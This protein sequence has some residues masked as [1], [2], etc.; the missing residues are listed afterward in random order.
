EV[1]ARPGGEI[2]QRVLESDLTD[3]HFQSLLWKRDAAFMRKAALAVEPDC[4]KV[5][6][7]LDDAEVVR[8]FSD[9]GGHD[10]QSL[11]EAFLASRTSDR[12]T[13]IVAHTIKGHRLR[14]QAAT[15]NHSA[16]PD[17]DEV[18]ELL[19]AAGL[20]YDDPY[21]RFPADSPEGRWLAERGRYLRE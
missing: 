13:L 21:A 7:T 9:L 4:R 10:L 16:L 1:F 5:L 14:S 8:V 12:P 17:E 11:A 20:S 2:L 15:G 3:F 18:R 6:D 19:E